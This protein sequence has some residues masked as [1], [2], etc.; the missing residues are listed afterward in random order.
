MRPLFPFHRISFRQGLARPV[1][2]ALLLT[3]SVAVLADDS[4]EPKAAAESPIATDRPTDSASPGLVP[5]R[6]LQFETG[7][8]FTRF[9]DDGEQTDSHTA[10][11]LLT[12]YG[13]NRRVEARLSV[14]GWT[15]QDSS[16]GG[17]DG[18]NDISL[19][20]KIAL[21][22][23]LGRRPQM[24]LLVDVSL[25]VGQANFTSDYLIPKVLFL[26]AHGL[27]DRVGLTYNLG[28]SLVTSKD[29]G[30]RR[31]DVDLN[32]AVAL[33]GAVGASVSLFG[34]V[35]GAFTFDG[36]R[37]DRHAFQAGATVLLTQN[38]QIDFR[39][40]FGMVDNEPDW[41]AGVGLAFRLPI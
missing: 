19:G 7:H 31:T 30:G 39:G 32:Y 5:T 38:L 1:L 6:T 15:I 37:P 41:L 24:G 25:P 22:E 28:P 12:R 11:D 36:D 33:S 9:E 3:S 4:E 23:E 21:A 35:Y 40:G 26:A 18:F 10:P 34:E 13:I 16:A 17:A 2:T 8:K 29:D 27:T 20:T 14:T